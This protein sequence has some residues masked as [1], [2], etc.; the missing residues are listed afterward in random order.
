MGRLGTPYF[1]SAD[2]SRSFWDADYRVPVVLIFGRESVGLSSDLRSKYA[3][4]LVALPQ[5]EGSV[6]SL[7]LSN[8]VAVAAYEV[9]R[10]RR[11]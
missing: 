8:T 5:V 1:Y 9:L 6:R 10:Q 4:S 3:D 11:S 2:A 7:N